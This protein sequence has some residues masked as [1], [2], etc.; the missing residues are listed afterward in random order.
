M[1]NKIVA[2]L[3]AVGCYVFLV[4]AKKIL[5][6]KLIQNNNKFYFGYRKIIKLFLN[7]MKILKCPPVIVEDSY[8]MKVFRTTQITSIMQK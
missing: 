5:F 4:S 7:L 1:L 2:A 6:L 3:I 8:L